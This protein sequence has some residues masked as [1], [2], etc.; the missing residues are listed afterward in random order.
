M[1][2]AIVMAVVFFVLVYYLLPYT[3]LSVLFHR[4]P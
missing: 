1:E 4:C 2:D 3:V